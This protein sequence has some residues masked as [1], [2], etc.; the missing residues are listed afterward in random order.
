[1]NQGESEKVQGQETV[2]D[3]ERKTKQK[4]KETINKMALKMI[5]CL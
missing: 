4:N 2:L 3:T 5:Q 1:M